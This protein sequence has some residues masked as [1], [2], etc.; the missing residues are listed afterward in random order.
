[1]PA[2]N[3]QPRF[4]PPI[5]SGAKRT[6]IRGKPAK[7][8]GPA[9]LFTGMRTK[10][11]QRLGTSH[12]TDCLPVTLGWLGNGSPHITLGGRRLNFEQ[13]VSMAAADGFETPREMLQW[14]QT[15]YKVPV[16]HSGCDHDVFA[17]FW[18]QWEPL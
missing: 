16:N 10:A 12:V 9:Y 7:V 6:T 13:Q 11:C 14:F 2:Y 8:G 17:G 18:I 15:T 5:L 1:M 4:A 3:F